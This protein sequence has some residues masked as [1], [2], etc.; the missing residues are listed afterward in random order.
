M[1]SSLTAYISSLQNF[2][3]MPALAGSKRGFF[4]EAQTALFD[5]DIFESLVSVAQSMN[6][7]K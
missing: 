3:G 1:Q 6:Q 7:K 2:V 4:C 5:S